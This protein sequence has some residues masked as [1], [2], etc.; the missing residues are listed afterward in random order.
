MVHRE[1]RLE[2]VD[3]AVVGVPELQPRVE[4]QYTDWGV[5]KFPTDGLGELPDA[6][7]RC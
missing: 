3:S 7:Q 2:P 1:G 6:I 5:A 4:N